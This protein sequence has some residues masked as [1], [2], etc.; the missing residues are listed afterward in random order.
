M[1]GEIL[2]TGEW[3]EGISWEMYTATEL[4]P[5][6]LCTAVMCV[7]IHDGKLVLARSER[8]WGL[9]GGHIEEGE[10]QEDALFREALEEGGFA[11]DRYELFAVKAITHKKPVPHQQTGKFYPFPTGYMAYYWA[12]SES[13]LLPYTGEE[14][15]ESA[16]FL[17]EDVAAMGLKDQHII[18]FGLQAHAK[19]RT[20]QSLL[21]HLR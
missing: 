19:A 13:S 18:D 5:L 3:D 4:P 15:L 20:A 7:A 12:V 10:T 16:S 8:G 9:L 2:T 11:I 6:E 1:K 17:I 14:I 21:L